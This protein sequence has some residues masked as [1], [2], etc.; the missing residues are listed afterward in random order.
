MLKLFG[1]ME[2][3]HIQIPIN[4]ALKADSKKQIHVHRRAEGLQGVTSKTTV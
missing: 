4:V 3:T 2:E 1:W